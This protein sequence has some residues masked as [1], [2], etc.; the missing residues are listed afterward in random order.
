[1]SETNIE[2]CWET[3]LETIEIMARYL[4][5]RSYGLLDLATM[6]RIPRQADTTWRQAQKWW[7]H[8]QE[9]QARF[10]ED[11]ARVAKS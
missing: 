7:A 11:A 1:M 8:E 9:L 3:S 6:M 5:A 2:R 4:N 10:N